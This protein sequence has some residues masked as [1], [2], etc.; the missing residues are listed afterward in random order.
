MSP[1]TAVALAALAACGGHRVDVTGVGTSGRIDREYTVSD[2]D[3]PEPER[4]MFAAVQLDDPRDDFRHVR[5]RGLTLAI[6]RVQLDAYRWGLLPNE[7]LDALTAGFARVRAAGIKVILRFAYNSGE[8]QP[9]APPD[10]I[11]SHI[12][13][14]RPLIAANADVI[15]V[16]HAGFIGEWGEWHDSTAGSNTPWARRAIVE[17]LLAALPGDRMLMVRT[18][19]FKK[20]IFGRPLTDGD[21][22]SGTWIA[23]VGHHDDCFLASADDWGTYAAPVAEW[24]AYVAGEGR[25]TPVGGDTCRLA[26]PRTNCPQALAELER[27]HW[28]ML[29]AVH[30]KEVLDAW[31]A[32]G[33]LPEIRRRLGYRFALERAS[34]PA[35]VTAGGELPVWIRLRNDGF[36]SPFN[37]RPVELVLACGDRTERFAVDADPRRWQAGRTADVEARAHVPADMPPGRCTLGLAFPDPAPTLANR[38]DYAIRLANPGVWDEAGGYNVLTRD[39]L[40]A[41]QSQPGS[42]AR[43]QSIHS[44]R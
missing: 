37:P 21:A 3:L 41:P 27:M 28:S 8:G 32:Q 30:K 1:R 10:W 42:P 23:R 44:R 9:D 11:M 4:G 35:V 29:N 22:F 24:K 5:G 26:P 13:Q 39:L 14:L 38:P 43:R 16:M 31:A 33:C 36:A 15:A 20:E 18:P 2:D 34:F 6:A 40:V 17:A 19:M 12:A 25:W 7:L